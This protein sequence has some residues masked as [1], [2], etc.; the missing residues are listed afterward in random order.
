MEES[1]IQEEDI[2]I[3][4]SLSTLHTMYHKH[5]LEQNILRIQF[6][7]FSIVF[8]FPTYTL[9]NTLEHRICTFETTIDFFKPLFITGLK[10]AGVL[11]DNKRRVSAFSLAEAMYKCFLTRE[12]NF[13]LVV[14]G[15]RILC[16]LCDRK[17]D[18]R[19][20]VACLYAYRVSRSLATLS[21]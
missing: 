15:K 3:I 11:N 17:Y 20:S 21:F 9:Q 5:C 7:L 4:S 14:F 16:F 12:D 18:L 2:Q 8:Q 10:L 19:S 1:K 13:L 6:Y